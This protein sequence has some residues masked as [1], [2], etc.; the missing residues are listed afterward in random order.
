MDHIKILAICLT[1]LLGLD[2]LSAYYVIL[3]KQYLSEFPRNKT[4]KKDGCF[5]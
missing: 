3:F 5:I 4:R 1:I 2:Q